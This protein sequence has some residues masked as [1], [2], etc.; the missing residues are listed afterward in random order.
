MNG[1]L[2]VWIQLTGIHSNPEINRNWQKND[3]DAL[4]AHVITYSIWAHDLSTSHIYGQL[5]NPQISRNQSIDTVS[6][7][8]TAFKFPLKFFPFCTSDDLHLFDSDNTRF[9]YAI[10]LSCS[11]Y[12]NF[13]CTFY[14]YQQFESV[15]STFWFFLAEKYKNKP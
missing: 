2:H 7:T 4:S 14:L 12:S 11:K 6:L 8:L 3:Y 10:R 1:I 15:Q 9:P 13:S 5:P